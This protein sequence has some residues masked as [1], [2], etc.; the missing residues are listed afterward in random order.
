M[1]P[2]KSFETARKIVK[3]LL[4]VTVVLCVLALL[5]N[6]GSSSL[7]NYFVIAAMACIVAIILVV[8]IG[9]RCP[10]CGR[11]IVR[12]CLVVEVCPHCRR[13]LATGLKSKKKR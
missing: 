2:N 4:G 10:Y 13:N 6:D 12:K 3:F 11:T 1:K 7:V 8:A 9:M 5:F